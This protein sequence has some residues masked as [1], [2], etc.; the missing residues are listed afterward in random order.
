MQFAPA[1]GP[2]RRNHAARVSR[3]IAMFGSYSPSLVDA[4]WED[5]SWEL[6]GHSTC[7]AWYRRP[8]DRYFDLHPKSCWTRG[9]KKGAR[10]PQWLARNIVPIYM[11]KKFDE[12]PASIEY[13]KRRILQEFSD[14]RPYF[15]NHT[16]WMIALAITEGVSTIGL[17]GIDYQSN[18]EYVVQRACAEYWLG[19]AHSRGVQI[20]LPSQCTLLGEPKLL[21]GYESHDEV[22]GVLKSEYGAK[23]SQLKLSAKEPIR[24][25]GQPGEHVVIPPALKEEMDIEEQEFPRP[26]GLLAGPI[27][28]DG[29]KGVD[30]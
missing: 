29:S 17:F 3:K 25:A 30:A 9:G 26:P 13:P 5:E 1:I 20:V 4:P 10:Y 7:R 2:G 8:M 6:W 11:Q 18:S 21:Y 16:A 23:F 15:T 12:V 27:N 28:T 24:V 19:L 22:T 14:P